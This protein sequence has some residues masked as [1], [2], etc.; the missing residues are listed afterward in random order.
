MI[1]RQ[2]DRSRRGSDETG[3]HASVSKTYLRV[4][5]LRVAQGFATRKDR[6]RRNCRQYLDGCL[7]LLALI[8]LDRRLAG[9]LVRHTRSPVRTVWVCGRTTRT[10]GQVA[11]GG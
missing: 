6:D 2:R 4:G 9:E 10:S 1:M 5:A 8:A 11:S 3:R 7:A